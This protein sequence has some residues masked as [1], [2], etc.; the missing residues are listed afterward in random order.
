M[1]W[2]DRFGL[3]RAKRGGKARFD[4][5]A[6]DSDL[7]ALIEFHGS[8]TGV[9]F[10]VEPETFATGTTAVAVASDG[11]WIRRRVGSPAVIARVARKLA[12][13]VYDVQVVGYPQR[14]RDW[15]TRNKRGLSME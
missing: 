9:E 10:F 15:T 7:Q 14:M 3:R 2:R 4:R 8:R 6:E 13:P 5:A 12:A 11:E 1:G